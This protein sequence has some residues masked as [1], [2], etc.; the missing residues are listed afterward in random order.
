MASRSHPAMDQLLIV[1]P[2]LR[3]LY[4][5]CPKTGCTTIKTVMAAVTGDVDPTSD[6]FGMSVADI[7]EW[8]VRREL[9]WSGLAADARLRLLQSPEVFRF[10]S[11][12]DP[13][14]RIVSCYLAKV[15]RNN[16]SR[17]RTIMVERGDPT[18]LGFLQYVAE[19]PPLARDIHCRRMVDLT[20]DG[21]VQFDAV[22]RHERFPAD[23]RAV[24]E[25]LAVP[26]LRIPPQ[27][28]A[29]PTRAAER[30]AELMGSA[31]RALAAEIYAED[32]AAF[33]YPI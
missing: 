3:A 9:R 30:V 22:V 32:F 18:L 8:W 14:E 4:V 11:V 29:R 31:E 12:R 1:T 2:D 10:T 33:G 21:A 19:T 20:G 25:R 13:Y 23:L 17:L 15:A 28:P 5:S 6:D 27:N 26:G 16:T 7:H 24:I